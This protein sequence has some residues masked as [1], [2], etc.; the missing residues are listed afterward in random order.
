MINNLPMNHDGLVLCIGEST[1]PAFD[2]DQAWSSSRRRT[3]SKSNLA[4][5]AIDVVA[6]RNDS[7]GRKPSWILFDVMPG[8][9]IS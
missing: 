6:I 7:S 5:E 4:R 8:R 9:N 3:T 2:G 1:Y